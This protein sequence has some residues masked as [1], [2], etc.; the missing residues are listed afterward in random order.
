MS[1]LS[2]LKSQAAQLQKQQTGTHHNSVANTLSCEQACRNLRQYLQDLGTQLN[3]IHPPAVGHY[4]LDGKA[5][6]AAMVLKNFRSDARKK[7]LRNAEV[8]DSLGMGWELVPAD[9]AV[10]LHSVTVNFPPDLERVTQ[11]LATGQI[12]HER[13]DIRHP[14]TQKLLAYVFEYQM[15]SR[16]SI[17]VTPDHDKGLIAF[18]ITNVGGFELLT[19]TYPAA[20]VTQG[21]MDELAK[22]LVGQ[23]SLFA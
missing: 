19:T 6:F 17:L 16:G 9:G 4:S 10:T 12:Q 14:E 23:A 20:E 11:R 18:R 13:K 22:K 7:M 3:V 8:F 1:F 5:K 15:H 2:E 21:L